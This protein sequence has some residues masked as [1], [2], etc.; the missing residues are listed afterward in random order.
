MRACILALAAVATLP[1]QTLPLADILSRVS[2]E[3]EVFRRV[4]PQTLSE[5]TLEQRSLKPPPRFRPRVID[6]AAARPQPEYQTRQIVSEY[7]YAALKESPAALLEFRQVISVDGRRVSTPE[8]ARHALS[9]GLKSDDDRARKRMLEDFRKFGLINAAMD[10]GQILLLFTRRQLHNYDFRIEGGDRL[11]ADEAIVLTYDQRQ[12]SERMLVFQGKKTIRAK[13]GGKLWV[14]KSDGLPLRISLRSEWR[15][16]RLT[17]RH[18]AVVE[19][20][21][22]PFG[23]VLPASVKHTE[24]LDKQLVTEDVFR[25]A[26]FK[27]FGADAEIKFDASP[28]PKTK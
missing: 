11:G 4:A 5:E 25:Y 10:F 12:G 23:I 3:A 21:P 14:R 20:A 24:F 2:E 6:N 1:A 13:L 9:L 15:E 22:S 8:E 28:E 7:S 17:R 19:Y 16:G 26:P 18:D 27:K